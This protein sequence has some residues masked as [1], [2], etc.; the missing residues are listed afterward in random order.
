MVRTSTRTERPAL[1]PAVAWI[2]ELAAR[3]DG[4]YGRVN[5][6]Q[7]GLDVLTAKSH[8]YISPALKT[9]EK[10]RAV[11]LHSAALVA[12]PGISMPAVAAADPNRKEETDM[13]IAEILR[14]L[15]LPAEATADDSLKEIERLRAGES[16]RN[17]ALLAANDALQT[18]AAGLASETTTLNAERRQTKVERAIESGKLIPAH[19]NVALTLL[20][21]SESAFDT[22]CASM[23]GS[24]KHLFKPAFTDEMLSAHNLKHLDRPIALSTEAAKVAHTLGIKRES[25]DEESRR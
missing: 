4:L 8:R 24:I 9:D 16:D 25:L 14:A 11:W 1:A 20:S 12:A 6:L 7:P 21:V 15:G 23:E 17:K 5:W 22:F 19:R 13:N 10:G 2:E 18:M 3:G